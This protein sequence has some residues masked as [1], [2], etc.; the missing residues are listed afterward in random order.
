MPDLP[1]PRLQQAYYHTFL[2][3]ETWCEQS[4]A[5]AFS[6]FHPRVF[7]CQRRE[8]LHAHW[9]ECCPTYAHSA[10]CLRF[11]RAPIRLHAFVQKPIEIVRLMQMRPIQSGRDTRFAWILRTKLWFVGFGLEGDSRLVSGRRDTAKICRALLRHFVCGRH[12]A[13]SLL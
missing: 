6:S 11:R 3:C 4:H 8:L 1:E 7:G 9:L 10:D 5:Y 2:F 12:W 13:K